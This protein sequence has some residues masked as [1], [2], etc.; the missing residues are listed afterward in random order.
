MT[1]IRR[2]WIKNERHNTRNKDGSNNGHLSTFASSSQ[3]LW[4]LQATLPPLRVAKGYHSAPLA[5][6]FLLLISLVFASFLSPSG[7]LLLIFHPSSASLSLPSLVFACSLAHELCTLSVVPGPRGHFTRLRHTIG[8][9]DS[10]AYWIKPLCNS[11]FLQYL[12]YAQRSK[13][14]RKSIARTLYPVRLPSAMWH[15]RLHHWAQ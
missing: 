7:A 3:G 9:H 10:V 1:S 2:L 13:I 5:H 15:I 14:K 12:T 4:T 11:Y 8:Q 6:L